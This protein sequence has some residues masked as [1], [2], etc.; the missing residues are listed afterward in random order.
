[1]EHYTNLYSHQNVVS[2]SALDA[3]ECMSTLD[4]LDDKPTV[5]K[6]YNTINSKAPGSDG[7]PLDLIK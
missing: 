7:I 4:G 6:L 3:V 5:D 1:V 2:F